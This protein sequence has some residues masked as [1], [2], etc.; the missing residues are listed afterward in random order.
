MHC[1]GTDLKMGNHTL[2]IDQI[3]AILINQKNNEYIFVLVYK[4]FV[5]G[6]EGFPVYRRRGY[7][8]TGNMIDNKNRM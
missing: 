4:I 5:Y 8:N 6:E 1:N 3:C 2:I 7:D